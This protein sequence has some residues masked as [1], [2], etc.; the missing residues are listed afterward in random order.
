MTRRVTLYLAVLILCLPSISRGDA[1]PLT[2]G[3]Y[4]LGDS[5]QTPESGL[6]WLT[7]ELD[8][9]EWRPFDLV[10]G[11]P[12]NGFHHAWRR[13][14]LPDRTFEDPTLLIREPPAFEAYLGGRLI[15][16]AGQLHADTQNNRARRSRSAFPYRARAP[17]DALNQRSPVMPTLRASVVHCHS[18]G[19]V[20]HSHSA[21]Q[22][23]GDRSHRT[24]Q[25]LTT[26]QIQ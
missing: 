22:A 9:P 15:Y 3:E 20:A 7:A 17:P 26:S 11:H 8:S 10:D 21:R 6:A 2:G 1:V 19:A 14:R 18:Q 4:R 25:P 16:K 23:A 13:Y 5:P 12:S 24:V